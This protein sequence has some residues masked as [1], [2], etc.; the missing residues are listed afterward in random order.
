MKN[1]DSHH[2]PYRQ[3]ARLL[4]SLPSGFPPTD[5]G[6]ELRL[7]EK[8]YTPEEAAL[9]AQ[10]TPSKSTTLQI[11]GRTGM[12]QKALYTLLK[13]MTRKGLIAAGRTPEGRMGFGLMPFVVGIYEAQFDTMDAELAQLFE[14][15]YQ[16]A[17]SRALVI[18]PQL[19]RVIPV[20]ESISANIEIHPYESA[21]DI[22]AGAQAWGVIDCI[23]RKQKLLIGDPCEHPLD[24]CMMMSQTPNAFNNHPAVRSLAHEEALDALKRAA[25]A[26]LV[27]TVSN[28]QQGL[29]CLHHNTRNA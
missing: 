29:W 24:V 28:N 12:D 27:H 13:D 9:A 22:I 1:Q 16:Q 11:A 18:E 3:L 26:G 7:L 14:D 25:D 8:L 4:D 10:L 6:A 19:H 17:F 15:Y 2:D 21:A 20:G 5:T 23:C